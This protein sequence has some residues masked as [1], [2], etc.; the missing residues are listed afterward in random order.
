MALNQPTATWIAKRKL[1]VGSLYLRSGRNLIADWA[2]RN[3]LG[4]F[5]ERWRSVGFCR[6]LFKAQWGDFISDWKANQ[7]E[8]WG[9]APVMVERKAPCFPCKC[10]EWNSAGCG[11]ART[12][13]AMGIQAEHVY[14]RRTSMARRIMVPPPRE[15]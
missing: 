4:S 6:I 13:M 7:L 12:S 9:P 11:L 8:G 14:P 5:T 1:A 2:I 15:W 3:D 10:V